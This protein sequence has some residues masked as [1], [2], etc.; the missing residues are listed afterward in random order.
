M[1]RSLRFLPVLVVLAIAVGIYAGI[2]VFEALT[3]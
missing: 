2:V 1:N 3:G